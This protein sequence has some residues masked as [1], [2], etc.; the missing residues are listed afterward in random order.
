MSIF[1]ALTFEKCT[2]LPFYKS[3]K[4]LQYSLSFENFLKN[5]KF[6][7]NFRIHSELLLF[8][9]LIKFTAQYFIRHIYLTNN[10]VD[11]FYC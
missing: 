7:K 9:N 2:F 8:N 5:K 3:L 10:L 4:I 6:K 1:I 11:N